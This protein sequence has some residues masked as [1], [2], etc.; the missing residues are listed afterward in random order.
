MLMQTGAGLGGSE[1][2]GGEANAENM[3]LGDGRFIGDDAPG[4]GAPEEPSE[5]YGLS[6]DERDELVEL[7]WDEGVVNDL[8]EF[9]LYLQEIRDRAGPGAVAWA[10]GQWAHA[11]IL[12][13]STLDLATDTLFRRVQGVSE[14]RPPDYGVRGRLC[15]GFAGFQKILGEMHLRIAQRLLQDEWMSVSEI[16]DPPLLGP[17]G[18]VIANDTNTAALA[19]EG[20]GPDEDE[21]DSQSLMQLTREEEEAL[22]NLGVDDDVRRSLRDL[23]HGLQEQE[24]RDVGAE[25]R[26]GVQQVV[27]AAGDAHRAAECVGRILRDRVVPSPAMRSWPCQRAML[28]LAWQWVVAVLH[29]TLLVA[30]GLAVRQVL[31]VAV[32]VFFLVGLLLYLLE[33]LLSLMTAL[34][35]MAVLLYIQTDLLLYI[36]MDLLFLH[37]LL[38]WPLVWGR[39][40]PW[41]LTVTRTMMPL[42]LQALGRRALVLLLCLV[43][44]A[45]G[46]LLMSMVVDL[47]S[48]YLLRAPFLFYLALVLK[49]P[50]LEMLVNVMEPLQYRREEMVGLAVCP[51]G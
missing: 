43:C 11:L 6:A 48:L 24:N 17:A 22:D 32:S 47:P 16:G 12:A 36:P 21:G 4:P 46:E 19:F 27:E 49:N 3:S 35:Y 14:L 34:E 28:D 2:D 31:L 30:A 38:M 29:V 8:H 9:L 7:G 50:V 42:K 23:L 41:W 5:P 51:E 25:Y 37:V 15:V 33:A 44:P 40:L 26:W 13:E 1:R 18:G 10:V 39:R 45:P 20:A